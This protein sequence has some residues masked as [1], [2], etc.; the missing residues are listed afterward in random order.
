MEPNDEIVHP[1]HG[2]TVQYENGDDGSVQEEN[3]RREDVRAY[4]GY[5]LHPEFS[6]RRRREDQVGLK[7]RGDIP[8]GMWLQEGVMGW[9][10][11]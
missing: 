1:E 10:S 7:R 2:L 6:E 8:T 9:A 11:M 4:H 3:I 5:V